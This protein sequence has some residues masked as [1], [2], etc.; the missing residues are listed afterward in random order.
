MAIRLPGKLQNKHIFRRS[1]QS[2]ASAVV[3]KGHIAVYVGDSQKRRFIVPISYLNHPSFQQ[4]LNQA[5]EEFGFDHPMGGITIPCSEEIFFDVT[6]MISDGDSSTRSVSKEEK[7]SE[8]RLSCSE[9]PYCGLCWRDP[10]EA[11]CCS[12]FVLEP[13]F[14]PRLVESSGGRIRVSPPDG[15]PYNSMQ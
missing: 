12:Y 5:E 11:I 13:S 7:L 15:R 6:Q 9:R 14:I 4:L 1:V 3:P 8:L 2:S 10:E